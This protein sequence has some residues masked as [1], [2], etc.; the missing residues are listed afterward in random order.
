MKI[1]MF[2]PSL[3]MLERYNDRIYAPK[4]LFLWLVE[5]LIKQG[6][7]VFVYSVSTLKTSGTL[8]SGN[9]AIEEQIYDA[10]SG[11]TWSN[12]YKRMNA[13]YEMDLASLAMTHAKDHG[14]DLVHAYRGAAIH[15]VAQFFPELPVIYTLHDSL[16]T[17]DSLDYLRFKRF[18]DDTYTAISQSQKK[19][20]GSL[21]KVR[22]VVY[23]G[24]SLSEFTFNDKKSPYLAFMGRLVPE[25]GAFDA[26]LISQATQ[27]TLK[28]STSS[29]YFDKPYYLEKIK[30]QVDGTLIQ[31]FGYLKHQD[32][33]TFLANAKAFLFPIHWEESFGMVML[34]S[35]ACGTPVIA[36]NRGSVAEVIKDGVTGFIV[37]PEESEIHS[38]RFDGEVRRAQLAVGRKKDWIIQKKGVAGL[39]EAVKRISEIKP[40]NC[41]KHVEENFS[42]EK[43]AAGYERVYKLAYSV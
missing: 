32:R 31:M 20:Y 24:L 11:E 27:M 5:G 1:G 37:E 18:S 36:Y 2:L 13:E 33:N 19:E 22:E 26:V 34:E 39:I 28:I 41:R 14:V 21:L 42:I 17:Q 6:H 30:P 43:M 40:I 4:P 16:P 15:Y 23:H 29:F 9:R 38:S 25:K 35:M 3:M 12:W 7:E 8:I 10:S